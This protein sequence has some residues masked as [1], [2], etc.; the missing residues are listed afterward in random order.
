M[1]EVH[2]YVHGRGHGHA[3][4]ALELLPALE[5]AGYRI[6]L[7]AGRDARFL[8]RTHCR[9]FPIHSLL[10]GEPWLTLPKLV[11]RNQR[12]KHA[13]RNIDHVCY[14]QGAKN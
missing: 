11:Q 6:R 5:S 4:R 3:A 1:R 9:L 13:G 12:A 10:P 2:Y 14:S 7:F 8:L